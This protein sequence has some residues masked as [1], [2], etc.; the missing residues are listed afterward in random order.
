MF[1]VNKSIPAH[2][3]SQIW[4][5]QWNVT[6]GH[7]CSVIFHCTTNLRTQ[8][9]KLVLTTYMKKNS[10]L[11]AVVSLFNGPAQI[12][13]SSAGGFPSNRIEC[14]TSY[15]QL[16]NTCNKLC[17]ANPTDKYACQWSSLP[18]D[19]SFTGL[20][21]RICSAQLITQSLSASDAKF[22][23]TNYINLILC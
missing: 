1:A 11:L 9:C 6:D 20:H 16:T 13:Q 15:H 19:R 3:S 7:I 17:L 12:N 4:R 5:V 21:I 23:L 22:V 8:S 14:L 10:M 18:P 2:F